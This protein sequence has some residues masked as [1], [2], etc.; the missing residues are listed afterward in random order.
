M[1]ISI[2]IALWGMYYFLINWDYLVPDIKKFIPFKN[3]ERI[4]EEIDSATRGIVHGMF[5]IAII[6]FAVASL[7]FYILGVKLYILL[8]ILMAFLVFIPGVG[9]IFVW[10]PT[11]L[12][13]ILT[14][15]YFRGI[16]VIVVGAIVSIGVETFLAGKIMEKKAKINP[17]M[18]FIG[19]LGGVA[20]F[21]IF[22]FVI[23]PLILIY[24]IKLLE[25]G[26]KAH[27]Q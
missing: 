11:A 6:E 2:L 4:A 8:A 3:K 17:L 12:F 9:P 19:V 15:N 27:S 13:Y 26:I 1:L 5:F 10:L 22:G 7:G 23:G 14:A 24:A 18:H 16:G 21:G 25:N 20:L